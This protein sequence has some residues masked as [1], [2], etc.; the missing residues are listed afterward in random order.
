MLE[1]NCVVTQVS[2][3]QHGCH[4]AP[5]ATGSNSPTISPPHSD[6]TRRT[7][8]CRAVSFRG[9]GAALTWRQDGRRVQLRC[10]GRT[11]DL[12]SPSL[13]AGT[14]GAALRPRSLLML[15]DCDTRLFRSGRAAA[16]A[17]VGA[18]FAG[19]AG[20]VA[21]LAGGQV[22]LPREVRFRSSLQSRGYAA[23]QSVDSPDE[24]RPRVQAVH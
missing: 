21:A 14:A 5:P 1:A 3:Q 11:L 8:T 4:T 6:Q 24:T 19:G 2:S 15:V 10:A 17:E 7:R 20:S 12:F 16:R 18:V 13:P 23:G 9:T 22:Q